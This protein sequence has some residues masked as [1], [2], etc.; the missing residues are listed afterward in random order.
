M[1][2][3]NLSP[4]S[5]ELLLADNMAR[6]PTE[7][8]CFDELKKFIK[9]KCNHC[10]STRL[11][12]NIGR[13][14]ARCLQCHRK[15]WVTAR[16]FLA[17]VKKPR[18][19]LMAIILL[20]NGILVNGATFARLLQIANSS[21]QHVLKKVSAV[22][23]QLMEKHCVGANSSEFSRCIV[24]RSKES[25]AKQ[26]PHAEFDDI[27]RQIRAAKND[28]Q[29]VL[30]TLSKDEKIVYGLFA[31]KPMSFSELETASGLKT[32]PLMAAVTMLELSSLIEKV[33]GINYVRQIKPTKKITT[34]SSK[35]LDRMITKNTRLIKRSFQGISRKYLQIYLAACWCIIDRS[36]WNVISLLKACGNAGPISSQELADYVSPPVVLVFPI[37]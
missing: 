11:A 17:S 13:R 4:N 19:Y 30:D 24:R 36:R 27:E 12:M 29:A 10:G 25:P 32:G 3:Q 6:F 28:E 18:L 37:P 14:D 5:L 15:T 9:I 31:E 1:Q 33:D 16:T 35:K 21:A 2:Q 22:L 8:D 34:K 7:Q 20:G 23:V 26:H